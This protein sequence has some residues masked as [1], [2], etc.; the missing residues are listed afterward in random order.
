M[1]GN[2]VDICPVCF[3]SAQHGGNSPYVSYWGGAVLHHVSRWPP[4]FQPRTFRV[5]PW[6]SQSDPPLLDFEYQGSKA[7]IQRLLRNHLWWQCCAVG[8]SGGT[9]R[10]TSWGM[11]LAVVPTAPLLLV[12]RQFSEPCSPA[13]PFIL[14][15]LQ[16]P[17]NTF[18]LG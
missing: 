1:V 18:Q 8:S 12:Y 9:S 7:K 16:Y 5:G 3:F 13:L 15:T 11:T 4:P 6:L 14:W 10:G 17:P 2:V